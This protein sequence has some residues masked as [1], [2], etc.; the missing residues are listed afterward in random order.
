MS[1]W[2]GH[3]VQ[4]RD[5]NKQIPHLWVQLGLRANLE[6]RVRD[7]E[8]TLNFS[9][10]FM[11]ISQS[12]EAVEAHIVD[13]LLTIWNTE[14]NTMLNFNLS[15]LWRNYS[16]DTLKAYIVDLWQWNMHWNQWAYLAHFHEINNDYENWSSLLV[17]EALKMMEWWR[18]ASL[19]YPSWSNWGLEMPWC[20]SITN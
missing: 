17:K 11:W 9:L 1:T 15:F 7:G 13:V 3:M 4:E 14:V 5:I 16:L 20:Y 10:S 18:G 6:H 12:L 19:R 2:M 8:I